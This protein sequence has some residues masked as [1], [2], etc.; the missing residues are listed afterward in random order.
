MQFVVKRFKLNS[1]HHISREP[2]P[3]TI[4]PCVSLVPVTGNRPVQIYFFTGR[5]LFIKLCPTPVIGVSSPI[6]DEHVKQS[7]FGKSLLINTIVIV[8]V[9]MFEQFVAANYIF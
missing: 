5:V 8:F 2:W 4:K 6:A 9:K 1:P 3:E 7:C